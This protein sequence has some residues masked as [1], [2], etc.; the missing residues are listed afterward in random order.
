MLPAKYNA[1]QYRIV[2]A[3]IP[4]VCIAE[5]RHFLY[6]MC[7]KTQITAQAP[8]FALNKRNHLPCVLV[9]TQLLVITTKKNYKKHK[10][11]APLREI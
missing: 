5:R 1:M 7:K 2:Y 9:L 11:F 8:I 10:G 6:K 4:D 3:K